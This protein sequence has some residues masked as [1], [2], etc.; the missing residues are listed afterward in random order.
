MSS[1]EEKPKEKLGD[2]M[3]DLEQKVNPKSVTEGIAILSTVD[4]TNDS[5]ILLKPMQSGAKEFKE[6]VGRNMTYSE[7]REMWG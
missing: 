2:I 3:K 1:N 4:K 5:S 7:I 6:R